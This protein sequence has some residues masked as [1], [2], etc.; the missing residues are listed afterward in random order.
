MSLKAKRNKEKAQKFINKY[1]KA[2]VLVD[3][4]GGTISDVQSGMHSDTE[5]LTPYHSA[6]DIRNKPHLKGDREFLEHA[7]GAATGRL[8][9]QAI[10]NL[11][12]PSTKKDEMIDAIMSHMHLTEEEESKAVRQLQSKYSN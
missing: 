7:V 8:M 2:S 4:V 6:G 9:R 11:N 12:V 1:V 5:M 3:I 10:M